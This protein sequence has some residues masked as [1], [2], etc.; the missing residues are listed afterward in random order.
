M[1]LLYQLLEKQVAQAPDKLFIVE[2]DTRWSFQDFQHKVN[3]LASALAKHGI[4]P[5]DRVALMYL[6]QKEFLVGFW[7]ILRVGG[8][9]VPMNLQLPPED[10]MYVIQDAG[11]RLVMATTSLAKAFEGKPIPVISDHQETP[12]F[13]AWEEAVEQG[14]PNFSPGEFNLQPH[15]M[16]IL[17]YTSGTTGRPKGVMLSEENL[18]SNLAGIDPVIQF[19]PEDRVL[20]ALPLFHAFGL[21]IG[22]YVLSLGGTLAL[23]PRFAPKKI[24]HQLA[25]EKITILPLVPTM[26]GILLEG[27]QKVGAEAFQSLRMCVS[28]GA[29]LPPDLLKRIESTLGITV[30]EGYGL[31]E[32]SPVLAVNNPQVGSIP[33]SVG[34]PLPNVQMKLVNDAGQDIP[35]N[36]GSPSAEGEIWVQG[37]NLMLGYYNLPEATTEVMS[38]DGWLKTGDLGHF[39]PDGNLFISGGR[40]KDLIIKA[41]ENIS[42]LRV[43]H[44]LHDHPAILDASVIGVPDPKL[45]EEV[46]A[47]VQFRPGQSATDTELKKFCRQH[48]PPFMVPECFRVYED[49][50]KNPTGKVLKKV[51]REENPV[52]PPSLSKVSP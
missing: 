36:A 21:I 24:L 28:G 43:E 41:G 6:N 14:D 7:A 3:R 42:P 22:I 33:R 29:S 2:D 47:C 45:G 50:P 5:G 44:V 10:M 1:S 31:T 32:T 18:L 20:L 19:S 26:F 51:L 34:K 48:L 16:R 17:M 15:T 9:V 52:L 25:T 40:K 23:V 46:L 35:W 49:L 27:A 37:P 12:T 39:D 11:C 13:P 38:A 30:L 8:V 4:Q